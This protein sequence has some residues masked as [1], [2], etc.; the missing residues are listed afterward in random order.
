MFS[1]TKVGIYFVVKG[2]VIHDSIEL[3]NAEPYGNA[4]QF[5]GH[6]DFH[7]AL[8]P[9]SKYEYMFKNLPYDYFPRGRVVY[10][11]HTKVFRIYHDKCISK[12]CIQE[13]LELFGL[14]DMDIEIELDEH[15]KCA[16]CNPNFLI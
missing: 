9:R 11:T 7:E 6:Y 2:Q 3:D 5:G 16:K 10:F 14:A 13:V 4:M 15:Y 8:N 12:T 1:K